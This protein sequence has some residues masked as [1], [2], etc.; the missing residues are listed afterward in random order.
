[1]SGVCSECGAPLSIGAGSPEVEIDSL[2]MEIERLRSENIELRR[3][4]LRRF[5]SCWCTGS[6]DDKTKVYVTTTWHWSCGLCNAESKSET[7]QENIVH[8]ID[9]PLHWI[10]EALK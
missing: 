7:D 6:Y 2:K 5:I 1:M 9:C 3:I 10:K 4:C 8:N